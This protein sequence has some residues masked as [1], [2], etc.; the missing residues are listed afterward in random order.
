MILLMNPFLEVVFYPQIYIF[1]AIAEGNLQKFN[2]TE[3]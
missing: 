2:I 1:E 3:I